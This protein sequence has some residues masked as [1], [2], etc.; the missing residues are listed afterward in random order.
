MLSSPGRI[1]RTA[2]SGCGAAT[3]YECPPFCMALACLLLPSEKYLVD[4]FFQKD[5]ILIEASQGSM[6]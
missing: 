5:K 6:K 1:Y 4:I 3:L 2:G